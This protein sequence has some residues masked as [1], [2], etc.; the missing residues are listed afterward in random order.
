MKIG[1]T[2]N[3]PNYRGAVV[4]DLTDSH[5]RVKYYCPRTGDVEMWMDRRHVTT[6]AEEQVR[7]DAA[8]VRDM[9]WVASTLNS[10]IKKDN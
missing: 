4:T 2:V 3:L 1:S 10:Q 6:D 9:A 7:P 8:V 5:V